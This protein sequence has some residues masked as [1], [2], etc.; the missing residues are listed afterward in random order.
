MAKKIVPVSGQVVGDC[1]MIGMTPTGLLIVYSEPIVM[2]A[3]P[4]SMA[5]ALVQRGRPITKV[6]AP[7]SV[8]GRN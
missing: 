7:D 6:P 3:M 1:L 4:P 5:D 2:S 8:A